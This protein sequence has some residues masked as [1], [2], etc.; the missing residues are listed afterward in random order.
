MCASLSLSKKSHDQTRNK[1]AKKSSETDKQRTS[2]ITEAGTIGKRLFPCYKAGMAYL[3]RISRRCFSTPF[4]Y[5]FNAYNQ[6][7]HDWLS[8]FLQLPARRFRRFSQIVFTLPPLCNFQ[9]LHHRLLEIDI[10]M[11]KCSKIHSIELI[12]L[13]KSSEFS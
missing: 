2:N 8:S 12:S 3:D 11:E 9:K 5:L 6:I 4:D 10:W 1:E 7:S 13:Q